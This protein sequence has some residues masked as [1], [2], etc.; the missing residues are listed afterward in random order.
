MG[1]RRERRGVFEDDVR[2]GAD[3]GVVEACLSF[4][5]RQSWSPLPFVR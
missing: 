2:E 3:A 4:A 1:C 5:T